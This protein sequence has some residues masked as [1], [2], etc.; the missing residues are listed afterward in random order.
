MPTGTTPP[1][2]SGGPITGIGGKCVDVAGSQTANGTEIQLWDCNGSGA[3]QRTPQADGHLI[4]PQSGRA[5]D[6]PA[7]S[8]VDGTRL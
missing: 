2:P 1:P 7:G 5:V 3:Q 6:D 4:N 8:T